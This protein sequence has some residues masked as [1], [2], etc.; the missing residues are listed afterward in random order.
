MAHMIWRIRILPVPT[1]RESDNGADAADAR[2]L[3]EGFG[4]GTAAVDVS[5]VA[6]LGHA[7]M[8]NL[9]RTTRRPGLARCVADE[10]AETGLERRDGIFGIIG[11][12]LQPKICV[13]LGM[14]FFRRAKYS[15][16][17]PGLDSDRDNIHSTR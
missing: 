9:A 11:G 13:G 10:H 3:G 7:S 1:G 8:A 4:I 2:F 15:G 6:R 14:Y 16:E 12:D 5:V 17:G